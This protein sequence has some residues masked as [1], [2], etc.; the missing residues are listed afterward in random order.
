MTKKD[1]YGLRYFLGLCVL[2]VGVYM[3]AMLTG[4]RFWSY[5]DYSNTKNS[6]A[7][8]THTRSTY[9]HK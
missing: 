3:Y 7:G 1:L 6:A 8:R 2:V 9:Y 4:W 5:G